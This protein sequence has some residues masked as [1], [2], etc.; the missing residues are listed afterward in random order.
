M[1]PFRG[2]RLGG[3]AA[4]IITRERLDLLGGFT[5]FH[6]CLLIWEGE[7]EGTHIEAKVFFITDKCNTIYIRI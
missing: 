5:K 3:W 1:V 6:F 2:K 4:A 7:G